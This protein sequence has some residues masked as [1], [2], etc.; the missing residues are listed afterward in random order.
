[1]KVAFVDF[2]DSFT[3]NLIDLF[4]SLGAQVELFHLIV[5]DEIQADLLVLGPGPGQP[6]SYPETQLWLKKRAK[7]IPILG[8][9]LGHQFLGELFGARV[10]QA[11]KAMHGKVDII[12]HQQRG[13]FHGLPF[14]FSV[15]RYHSLVL[16]LIPDELN[17]DAISSS[18]EV[19]AISH[20]T[21][22]IVGL[23]F[24]PESCASEMGSF[25]ISNFFSKVKKSFLQNAL[26]EC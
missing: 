16:D 5:P 10:I 20:K 2:N 18:N 12:S 3:Y 19:M 7:Q 13:I 1:M 24:H 26:Q 17:V 8:I 11:K 21:Y 4:E 23:Q 22:P 6:S 9:C 25:I 15:V 14:F